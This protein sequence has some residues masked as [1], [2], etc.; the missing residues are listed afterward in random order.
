MDLRNNKRLGN[1]FE[2]EYAEMLKEKG[3]WVLMVTPKG[4]INSQPMDIIAG[5]ANTLYC[6]ECKTLHSKNKRFNLDRIEQNQRLAYKR[7]KQTGNDNYYLVVKWNNE[8]IYQIPFDK[9]DF[10]QKSIELIE[11]YRID[12]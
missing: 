11:E 8:E 7:L 1:S 10:K 6:F 12:N 5:K 3:Y 9:I 2:K 4:Y